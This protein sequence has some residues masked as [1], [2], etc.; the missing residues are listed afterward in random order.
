[1][2]DPASEGAELVGSDRVLG[3]GGPPQRQIRIAGEPAH[4]PVHIPCSKGVIEIEEGRPDRIGHVHVAR[5][6]HDAASH[7]VLYISRRYIGPIYRTA[8]PATDGRERT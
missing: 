5:V 8:T 1:V 2:N 6:V 4:D 3:L 7:D